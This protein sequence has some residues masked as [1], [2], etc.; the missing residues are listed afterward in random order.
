M[1]FSLFCVYLCHAVLSVPCSLV[2]TPPGKV[3]ILYVKFTYVFLTF[4]YGVV[5]KVWYLI[6]FTFRLRVFK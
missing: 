5:G 3:L 4:P 1:H 2:V 6:I